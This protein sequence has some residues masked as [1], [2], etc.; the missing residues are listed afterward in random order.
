MNRLG[1]MIDVSH[2]SDESFYDVVEVSRA[3][4]IASHSSCRHF[5]PG[6]ERNMDDKMIRLLAEK[7]GVIQINFGSMFLTQE[8]RKASSQVEA[9]LD[10]KGV[11]WDSPE[12]TALIAEFR[13]AVPA[14][15]VTVM[16]VVAHI[17]HVVNL[18]GI[19]HIGLG[20]DYDGVGGELPVGLEDVSCY[21]NLIQE[22]LKKD[23][24]KEDVRKICS[25]NLLRV[26]SQVEEIAK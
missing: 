5:T 12:A 3:P 19:D 25:E 17:E 15:E 14:P 10:E 2:L 23:Y 18:V 24:S 7:G 8:Y 13:E 11:E 20:S 26:W 4:V 9:Y 6:W 22:L 1:I 21:P 16:D